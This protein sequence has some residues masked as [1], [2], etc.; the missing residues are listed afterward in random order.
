M[1]REEFQ[2]KLEGLGRLAKEHENR[3]TTE[4]VRE[5]LGGMEL[6]EE[7]Y[8]LVFAYLASRL[9]TVEGYIPA[10]EEQKEEEEAPLG[11][12]EQNFLE[13]YQQELSYVKSLGEEE[14]ARL[15]TEAEENGDPGAKAQLTEQLLPEVLELAR[16]FAGRGL[17]LG[18]LVQEG[19]IGLMLAMET[20]GLRPEES[21]PLEYLR[22]E[23]KEAMEQ[24]LS[25]QETEKQAGDLIAER[26]N[27]LRDGIKKLSDEL[28]RKVSVEELSVFLDMP[29]EEIEDL[30][31][32]AGEAAGEDEG[33]EAESG[34]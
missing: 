14:L 31:K 16:R 1:E 25:D 24:A 27:D 12:E 13:A 32:L 9:V 2:K 17:P 23:I 6:T 11:P 28:E 18:D 26:L 15:F 4:E 29:A 21:T 33:S 34:E 3:L 19:N 5:F 8:Q 10:K 22:Q 7:Q 20:L 30:L